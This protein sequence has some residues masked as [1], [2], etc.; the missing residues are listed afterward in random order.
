MDLRTSYPH[1]HRLAKPTPKSNLLRGLYK[2]TWQLLNQQHTQDNDFA[3]GGW[4]SVQY[5][6]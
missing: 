2:T 1:C 6:R 5:P 3:Q 4:F